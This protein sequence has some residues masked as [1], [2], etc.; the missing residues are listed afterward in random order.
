MYILLQGMMREEGTAHMR[1]SEC[2]L[3]KGPRAHE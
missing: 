2:P 3:S 1:N